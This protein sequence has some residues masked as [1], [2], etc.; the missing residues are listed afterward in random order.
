MSKQFIKERRVVIEGKPYIREFSSFKPAT[1]KPKTKE[2]EYGRKRIIGHELGDAEFMIQGITKDSLMAKGYQE[3]F[4]GTVKVYIV[5]END[6]GVVEKH[7]HTHNGMI[8]MEEESLPEDGDAPNWKI[9]LSPRIY[10]HTINDEVVRKADVLRGEF[11]YGKGDVNVAARQ[12]AATGDGIN[13]NQVS[14]ALD[15]SASTR[16]NV[17]GVNIGVSI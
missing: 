2:D 6:E 14:P 12:Q 5:K 3:S 17:N 8:A 11:N 7:V 13:I 9:T 16:L 10:T 4:T 1:M 15:I